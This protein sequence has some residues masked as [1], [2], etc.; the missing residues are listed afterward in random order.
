[1]KQSTKWNFL[2]NAEMAGEGIM[3]FS[4]AILSAVAPLF[5]RT[6]RPSKPDKTMLGIKKEHINRLNSL[7]KRIIEKAEKLENE[8]YDDETVTKKIEPEVKDL[9]EYKANAHW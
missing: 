4:P 6:Y 2:L 9:K 1:M 3:L 5:D 7:Y 8:G